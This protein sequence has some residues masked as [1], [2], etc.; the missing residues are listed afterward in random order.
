MPGRGT[1]QVVAEPAY[2]GRGWFRLLRDGQ[3]TVNAEAAP[4]EGDQQ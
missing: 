4:P 1:A 2:K 3:S